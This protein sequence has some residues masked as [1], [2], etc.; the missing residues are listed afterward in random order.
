MSMVLPG[1]EQIKWTERELPRWKQSEDCVDFVC[2]VKKIYFTHCSYAP[3]VDLREWSSFK[4]L[5]LYIQKTLLWRARNILQNT[6]NKVTRGR[7]HSGQQN[8]KE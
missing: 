2:S 5:K 3:H 4:T 8:D 7:A 6:D 1:D